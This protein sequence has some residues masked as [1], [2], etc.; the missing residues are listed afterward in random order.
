MLN[1]DNILIIAAGLLLL[2]VD[3]LAFHDFQ[4]VHTVRDWIMLFASVLVFIEFGREFWDRNF[5]HR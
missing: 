4:E 1:I 5:G 2:A 3:W